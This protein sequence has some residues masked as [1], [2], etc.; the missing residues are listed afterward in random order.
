MHQPKQTLYHPLDAGILVD[1][2]SSNISNPIYILT[3]FSKDK[4]LS[5]QTSVISSFG[6][7]I[8]EDDEV[9]LDLNFKVVFVFFLVV[10][11]ILHCHII[12]LCRPW[13]KMKC[14]WW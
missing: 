12:F 9:S 3:N 10:I 11:T 6:I 4:I 14:F 7:T 2:F 5:N 13:Y 8:D 1:L